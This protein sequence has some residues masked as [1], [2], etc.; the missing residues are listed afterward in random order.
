MMFRIV[1]VLIALFSA[2]TLDARIRGIKLS[3]GHNGGAVQYGVN[4]LGQSGSGDF[5]FMDAIKMH[6]G[7]D[8]RD[9]SGPL[10]PDEKDANGWPIGGTGTWEAKGG[11]YGVLYVPTQ[12]QRSGRWV[13]TW[14]PGP[15][16][17]ILTAS[18]ISSIVGTTTS[19]RYEFIPD[20]P[21]VLIGIKSGT[22]TD[23]KFFHNGDE[24]ALNNGTIFATKFTDTLLNARAGVVRCMDWGPAN[25]G[26]TTTWDN[27]KP[28]SYFSYAAQESRPNLYVGSTGGSGDNYTVASVPGTYVYGGGASY[29][30]KQI[31]IVKFDRSS[32]GTAPTLSIGAG[33]AKTIITYWA[34][35]LTSGRR[36]AAGL[37]GL[38]IY[39]ATIDAWMKWGGD[40]NGSFLVNGVPPEMCFELGKAIGAHPYMVLP[41]MA[42]DPLSDWA[43]GWYTY[44]RDNGPSWMIPRLEGPNELWHS[45]NIT[46]F[47]GTGFAWAKE[48][49]RN[50]VSAGAFTANAVTF[51]FSGGVGALGTTTINFTAPH[52]WSVGDSVFITGFTGSNVTGFNNSNPFVLEVPSATSIK[53]NFAP[54]Q[55]TAVWSSGGT[56]QGSS[57][58]N[59]SW[60]GRVMAQLGQ[61]AS[62]VYSGN[63][64]RYWVI[65]GVQ[66]VGTTNAQTEVLASTSYFITNGVRAYD[67][68]THIANAQYWNPT[69]YNT[70]DDVRLSYDYFFTHAGNPSAQDADMVAFIGTG[71]MTALDATYNTWAT[72]AN[73]FGP[74]IGMTGYEGG[75]SP[76][77]SASN[78]TSP[79]TG[80]T[81]T[82]GTTVDLTLATTSVNGTSAVAGNAVRVGMW[83]AMS[84][85]GG[86]TQLNGNTYQVAAV[87]GST[88]TITVPSTAGFSAYTSGGSAEYMANNSG[89]TMA[90]VCNTM[91][92]TS[93]YHSSMQSLTATN[94]NSFKI[95]GGL[96]PSMFILTAGTKFS[97]GWVPMGS[98]TV[99]GQVWAVFD[100]DVYATPAPPYTAGQQFNFLLRRDVD[101]A[102]NDNDPM[103]L[104][105]AA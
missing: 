69:N 32:T 76:D 6:Q 60:Y 15:G 5:P 43:S 78:T 40:T 72:W 18:T 97:S 50:A 53:I 23:L 44:V 8:Y 46:E 80:A 63:R 14:T 48:N 74:S 57:N 29:V 22:I 52:P 73:S 103:W 20:D 75:Y 30:D 21:R 12:A 68:V 89:L 101:P 70:L 19:G 42:A 25:T 28:V 88:V 66:T 85:V 102:S 94:L 56:A 58:F 82:S 11:A 49:I 100:P 98:P 7:W 31:A 37:Y 54:N 3:N 4:F 38:L 87:S 34:G 59:R 2:S 35:T 95:R 90:S 13:A 71:G 91:R 61:V 16:K 47:P 26:S 55:N 24:T 96:F 9:N 93:K 86:M 64:A 92:Y 39:D 62:T 104:E 45:S 10:A 17:E 67:W 83:L 81:V 36:P 51:D 1:V 105:K 33:P 79:V 77:Y 41:Y 84:S 65:A 27:R 99:A